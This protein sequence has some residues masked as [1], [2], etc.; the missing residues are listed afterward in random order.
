MVEAEKK[1]ESTPKPKAALEPVKNTP[2][3]TANPKSVSISTIDTK[4]EKR[5]GDAGI[6]KPKKSAEGIKKEEMI[7]K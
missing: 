2:D 3:I 4:L 1:K 6:K 5:E 7:K